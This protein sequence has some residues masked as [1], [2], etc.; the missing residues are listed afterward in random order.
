MRGWKRSRKVERRAEILYFI[1]FLGF[2][3][4]QRMG[5]L[6]GG[7]SHRK[8]AVSAG[9]DVAEAAPGKEETPT[10]FD[11][12]AELTLYAYHERAASQVRSLLEQNRFT[13]RSKLVADKMHLLVSTRSGLSGL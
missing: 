6:H 3:R 9:V 13:T 10:E 1:S 8:V 11:Q 5:K 7:S 4:V 2:L 12:D